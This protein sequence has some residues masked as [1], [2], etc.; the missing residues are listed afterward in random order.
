V[1]EFE[2]SLELDFIFLLDVHPGVVWFDSQPVKIEHRDRSGK[3][4]HYTPDFLV[5]FCA[6][7]GCDEHWALYE[8]KFLEDLC[9]LWD[10]YKPKLAAA[11][12]YAEARQSPFVVLTEYE[13][14][15]PRLDNA[16]LLWENCRRARVAAHQVAVLEL[17]EETG[18]TTIGGFTEQLY[19][20]FAASVSEYV[21][22][23]W[24][25]IADS[26][27]H[28]NLDSALKSTTRIWT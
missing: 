28:C 1:V 24:Q 9:K 22:A 4:S 20:H 8:I 11:G 23:F 25:L 26:D 7:G 15:T 2:S 10:D 17:I 19:A 18:P 5:H 13:I 27:I 16:K 6:W 12:A 3:L 21:I 14:R